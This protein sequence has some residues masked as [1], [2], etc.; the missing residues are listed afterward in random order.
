MTGNVENL[1][2]EHLRALRSDMVLVK[3]ELAGVKQRLNSVGLQLAQIYN[4]IAILPFCMVAGMPW[5][6]A[7]KESSAGS[8]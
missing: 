8:T 5:S 4:D 2:L 7:S 3:E 6:G 1:I